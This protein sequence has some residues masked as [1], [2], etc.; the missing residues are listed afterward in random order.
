MHSFLLVA[1]ILSCHAIGSAH[2]PAVDYPCFVDNSLLSNR[3]RSDMEPYLLPL[4]HPIKEKLD[5]I[6][7]QSRVLENERTL[8]E[9]G[10]NIIVPPLPNSFIIIARHPEVP[11]YVFKF[12]LDSETRSRKQLP[13]WIWLVR[14]CEQAMQIKKIIARKQVQN[15]VIADKWLYILPVYPPSSSADPQVAIVVETDM[16]LDTYEMSAHMWKTAI[17]HKH[18]KELYSLLKHGYGGPS[19][20]YPLT[21]IPY[22]KQGKFAFIDTEGPRSDLNLKQITPYLSEEMQQYWTTLI[23]K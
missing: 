11:G 9:A 6:F 23:E 13:H 16:E 19:V 7:L 15:F 18:L 21:N 10:F 2:A 20:L 1:C 8:V 14:R 5:C 22:T 12:H 3:M 17:T 4:D